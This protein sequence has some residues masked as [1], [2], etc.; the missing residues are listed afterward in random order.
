[1][2]TNDWFLSFRRA[3]SI[4]RYCV[5]C[6]AFAIACSL[7]ALP[8]NLPAGDVSS[9]LVINTRTGELRN[10]VRYA[11]N[12]VIPPATL[13]KATGS[14]GVFAVDIGVVTGIPYSVRTL[15]STG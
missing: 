7:L 14:H 15:K 6:G 12:P 10:A 2:G 1:M 9:Q 13:A 3:A 5:A 11:P 8:P 4:G